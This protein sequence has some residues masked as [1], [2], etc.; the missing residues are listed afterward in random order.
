[1]KSSAPGAAAP[2]ACAPRSGSAANTSSITAQTRTTS[3]W[4]WAAVNRRHQSLF[5]PAAPGVRELGVFLDG[6][7]HPLELVD[8]GRLVEGRR[9]VRVELAGP[10]A[11]RAVQRAPVA[12]PPGP[13]PLGLR[14]EP[15][16]RELPQVVARLPGVDPERG[17]EIGGRLGAIE[18]QP[19]QDP[20][21]QRVR[22]PAQL[23][24]GR[25]D[26]GVVGG[27]SAKMSLQRPICKRLF[28]VR[29]APERA[30]D[31]RRRSDP[32]GVEAPSLRQFALP[33]RRSGSSRCRSRRFRCTGP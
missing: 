22:D 25:G 15:V 30:V 19:T 10:A 24:G 16:L 21:A 31:A 20:H 14:D 13:Q 32:D 23:L 33:V 8:D 18:P 9:G 27:H 2:G 17:R 29:C 7:L 28:A 26:R 5:V 4:A 3:S 12:L 1:M 6:G 11:G